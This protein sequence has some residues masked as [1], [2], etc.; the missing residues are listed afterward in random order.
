MRDNGIGIRADYLEQ[1]FVIFKRLHDKHEYP[2]TGIGLAIC[3]RIVENFRGKLW[4]E[5]EIG[6]GSVFYFTLPKPNQVRNAA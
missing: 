2:G 3:A 4:V 5:S 6:K 1:I